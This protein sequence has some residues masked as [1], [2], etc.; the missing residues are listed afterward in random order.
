M[1]LRFKIKFVRFTKVAQGL[2]VLLAAGQQ[3]RIRQVGQA[4]HGGAVF[5]HD[6]VQLLRVFCQTFFQLRH[7]SKNGSH[8]LALLF[9]LGDLLG[10]L[11]LPGLPGFG[12][13]DQ[14]PA[15]LIQLQ[16]PVN[17][18]VAVHFLGPQT[19]LDCF[20]VFLDTFDV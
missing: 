11:V 9:Q 6:S 4:Q 12:V 7:L 2:V 18:R 13:G 16:D 20:R 19:G 17:G 5:C 14:R 10:Y 8:I 3:V 1:M 15:L